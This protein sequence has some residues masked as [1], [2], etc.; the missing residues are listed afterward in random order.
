M[1][2]EIYDSL[3]AFKDKFAKTPSKGLLWLFGRPIED[4]ITGDMTK[5]LC[6]AGSNVHVMYEKTIWNR[7]GLA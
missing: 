7:S 6:I 4:I 5:L 2:N 1:Y 3:P